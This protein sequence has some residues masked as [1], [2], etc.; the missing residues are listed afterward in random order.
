MAYQ[1][2]KTMAMIISSVIIFTVY[3]LI[4]NSKYQNGD[5]S[6][7]DPLRLG[8]VILLLVIPLQIVSKIITMILFTMGQAIAVQGDPEIPIEDERDKVIEQRAMRIAFYFF[9][10]GFLLA[11]GSIALAWPLSVAFYLLLGSLFASDIGSGIAQFR[12]YRRGF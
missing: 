1:E 2:R 12:Y 10:G 8:A 4:L 6:N 9:G 3:V 11:M 5:F 7:A